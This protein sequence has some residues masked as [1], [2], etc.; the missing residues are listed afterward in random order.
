MYKEE[1][2]LDENQ[3]QRCKTGDG[4]RQGYATKTI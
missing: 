4:K 1:V 2:E 3:H